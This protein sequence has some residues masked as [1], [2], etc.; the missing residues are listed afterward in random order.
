MATDT[1]DQIRALVETHPVLRDFS[2]SERAVA[3]GV[4]EGAVI[5]VADVLRRFDQERDRYRAALA[6]I[7]DAESGVWGQIAHQA[8]HPDRSNGAA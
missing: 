6:R 5:A 3:M 4:V 2:D 8:L 7:S 1:R